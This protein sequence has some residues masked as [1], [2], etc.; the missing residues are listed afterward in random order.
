MDAQALP[1]YLDPRKPVKHQGDICILINIVPA[2]PGCQ[3]GDIAMAAAMPRSTF[4]SR[5]RSR[6]SGPSPNTFQRRDHLALSSLRCALGQALS[7][8]KDLS[9]DTDPSLRSG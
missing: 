8:A 3:G 6:T 2:E 7:A 4:F 9:P 1:D 5:M